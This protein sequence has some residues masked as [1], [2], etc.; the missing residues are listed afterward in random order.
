[1]IRMVIIK[2]RMIKI[3]MRR[4]RRMMVMRKGG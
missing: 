2:I 1:M 4:K 3:K